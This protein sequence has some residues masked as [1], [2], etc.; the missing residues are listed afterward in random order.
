MTNP[1]LLSAS[2]KTNDFSTYCR[3]STYNVSY[4]RTW[5]SSSAGKESC[6]A[7]DPSL[8]PGSRSF[9]GEGL[10]YPLQYSWAS[11]VAKTVKNPPAMQKTRAL[12]L[13]SLGWEDPLEEG[14]ATHPSIL[15]WRI[16]M[17]RGAYSPTYRGR[18]QSMR[19]QKV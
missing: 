14:I 10:G 1:I 7:R 9:P 8:I 17:S 3:K 4:T 13:G 16:L 12:S 5:A 6:N 15:A 11:M 18:L 19:S 2:V